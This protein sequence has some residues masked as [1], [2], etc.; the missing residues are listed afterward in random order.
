M[1]NLQA[2]KTIRNRSNGENSKYGAAGMHETR[3]KVLRVLE[4]G[5]EM[6]TTTLAT[7]ADITRRAASAHIQRLLKLG[8]LCER[9][10]LRHGRGPRYQRFVWRSEVPLPATVENKLDSTRWPCAKS[11]VQDAFRAMIAV[12]TQRAPVPYA[13]A[14]TFAGLEPVGRRYGDADND[15]FRFGEAANDSET[16]TT[17][18]N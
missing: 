5:G 14:V 13:N 17:Q 3:L 11:E 15:N 9:N 6:D 4:G 7:R 1:K 8:I 2:A 18:H 16:A 12:S 10:E